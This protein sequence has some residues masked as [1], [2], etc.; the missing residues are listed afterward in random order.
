MLQVPKKNH[1]FIYAVQNYLR[2]TKV[3]ANQ[4]NEDI[5][6]AARFGSICTI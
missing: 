6:C 5:R 4:L 1:D 2:S 3:V